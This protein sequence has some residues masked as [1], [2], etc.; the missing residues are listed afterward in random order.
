MRAFL[1][2]LVLAACSVAPCWGGE[3]LTRVKTQGYLR[4]GVSEGLPGMSVQDANGRW[5]GMD[6]DYCRAV[7]AALLGDPE[8]VRFKSLATL[9]RFPSLLAKEIDALARNTTWTLSREAIFKI[10]FAGPFLYTGQALMIPA[11]AGGGRLDDLNGATICVTKS[12]THVRNLDSLAQRRGL[13]LEKRL[14]DTLEESRLLL[15]NGECQAVTGDGLT[16]AGL[17]LRWGGPERYAIFPERY[18]KEPLSPA[19]LRDDEEWLLVLKSALAAIIG[20]EECGLTQAMSDQDIQAS[21]EIRQFLAESEAVAAPLGLR[22]GWALRAVRSVGNH[23]ELFERHL[24]AQSPLKV[25]RG[26]NRLWRDGGLIIA[27]P[28]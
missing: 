9:A 10:S 6:A 12:S 23:G 3:I 15:E 14:C 27:P 5:T 19:A 26:R 1:L 17:R 25:E 7:A 20:A 2:F 22:P 18:S 21:A 24:G 13:R 11:K 16:L 28:F 4:C 8:K